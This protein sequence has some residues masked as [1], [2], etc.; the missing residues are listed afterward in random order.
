MIQLTD[1]SLNFGQRA[2][3]KSLN[4]QISDGS[5]V[6]LVGNNGAGKTTLFRILLGEIEP[7][8]GSVIIPKRKNISYL[9]Q[10]LSE[11]LAPDVSLA[12]LFNTEKGHEFAARTGKV[13]KGLGFLVNTH[14]SEVLQRKVS[15]FSG[16][17]KMRL[18]LARV[19]LSISGSEQDV[20]LLDEPTNHLDTESMEWLENWLGSLQ[21]TVVAIAHD[22]RFLDKL[23]P[24]TAELSSGK[25]TLWKGNYSYYLE[26]SRKKR[27]IL[28]EQK[29]QQ[30]L[31]I[32]K[33][34]L[35]IDRFRYK[36][37]KATQVQSRIKALSKIE[38][39]EIEASPP[40]ASFRFPEARQSGYEI[41]KVE[42]VS[43]IYSPLTVF[44]NVSFS[45]IR[46]QKIALI[47]A[48]GAGKSTLSRLIS[49]IESPSNGKITLGHNVQCSYYLQESVQ[50]LDYSKTI[51]EE[52]SGTGKIDAARKRDLL[53]AFLFS[54]DDIYKRISVLSG[55]EKSR[56]ALLKVLLQDSNF[57]ILDEPTNHLD[58]STR[59]IF[60]RALLQYTGTVLLV[61]HDRHFLDSLVDRVLEI[62]DGRI[63]D[64][65]GNYSYFIYKRGLQIDD[66]EGEPKEELT[67]TEVRQRKR[68]RNARVFAEE[69]SKILARREIKQIE[70]KI[71]FLEEEIAK[72]DELLCNPEILSESSR[73]R[74]LLLKRNIDNNE[75]KS[76]FAKWEELMTQNL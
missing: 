61:S 24:N 15:E 11:G 12:E 60:E 7:D 10:D 28:M 32:E 16:G 6:A 14:I 42:D 71:D 66:A 30:E 45:I 63:W 40:E 54:G 62:R 58:A 65:P 55:G 69:K 36:A 8:S 18:Q 67:K 76:L 22:R 35:F 70:S 50:N 59:E 9:A 27:E 64:Y 3:Y 57:L 29:K 1:I 74:E 33:T 23:C 75:L 2:L 46:G 17:W 68:E 44:S 4:W 52:I 34:K 73:I 41:V 21:G 13:L 39:I 26:E 47:G 19:L 48:N 53:G 43:K 25:I 20:L 31:E 56:L 38:L 72:I 51:M 5:R 49:G 37:T